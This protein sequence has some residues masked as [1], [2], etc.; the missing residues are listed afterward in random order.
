MLLGDRVPV[1]LG[2]NEAVCVRDGLCVPLSDCVRLGD[3]VPVGLGVPDP[4]CV[5]LA[6]PDTLGVCESL[7]ERVPEAVWVT[8]P[9][10]V[11]LGV[12]ELLGVAVAVR[13]RLSLGVAVS[14]GLCVGVGVDDGEQ[15]SL[16]A[17]SCTGE[18]PAGSAAHVAR[19][20][21]DT[22]GDRGCAK[23]AAGKWSPAPTNSVHTRPGTSPPPLLPE[24]A[25]AAAAHATQK[26][27]DTK[28]SSSSAPAVVLRG[29]SAYDGVGPATASDVASATM[30]EGTSDVAFAAA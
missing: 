1:V 26:T 25:A 2:D 20:S 30:L 22:R 15:T 19:P 14:L 24:S 8:L 18:K 17:R 3:R 29:T 21:S 7:G 28:G 9:L 16:V 11:R 27:R 6:L 4:L 12:T 10:C 23:P 5:V 13:E